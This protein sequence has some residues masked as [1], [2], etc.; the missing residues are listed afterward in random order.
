MAELTEDQLVSFLSV[1]RPAPQG[2]LAESLVE[3]TNLPA[4]DLAA[5]RER[6]ERDGFSFEEDEE[7][8]WRLMD[9]PDKL[10]PYW[11]RA[12][13]R[14]DRLGSS[15]YYAEEVESTQDIAFEL[16][17]EGRSHG[18]LVVAEHQT[19]GRGRGE[20]VWHS[21]PGK[22][23]TFSLLLDLEPP[24]TFAS[25][26]TIAIA[27]SI[28]RAIQDLAGLPARIDFP[29]DI[30]VR[31]KKVAGILLEVKDYG[32]PQPRAVA[33]VGINV[34]QLPDDFPAELRGMASSLRI[35]HRGDDPIPRPRLLRYIL[36]GLEKW[37][38]QIAK[39]E[40]EELEGEWNRFAGI[41]DKTVLVQRGADEIRGR[42]LEAG[43]RSGL[44]LRTDSGQETIRLEH[45][46]ELRLVSNDS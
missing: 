21:T 1:F 39:G 2:L 14:C 46:A 44:R 17:V 35:E 28:A 33:G 26:L 13:L 19:A 11:I 7:G 45:V 40:F 38:D 30:V 16:M 36:R 37:L 34:N 8:R 25:V 6:L 10:L 18:T 23:L 12:G 43:I 24:D 15:V 4:D 20:R 22:S 5:Y 3:R 42:V 9:K 41:V 32:V 27:T 31:G 29:N